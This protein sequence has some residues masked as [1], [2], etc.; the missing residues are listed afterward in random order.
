VWNRSSKCWGP[1]APGP[2]PLSR[3]AGHRGR[4]LAWDVLRGH[5]PRPR[6]TRARV[7]FR[8]GVQGER[9]VYRVNESARGEPEQPDPRALPVHAVRSDP[10][11]PET[12]VRPPNRGSTSLTAW[13]SSTQ[14]RWHVLINMNLSNTR[15]SSVPLRGAD[16]RQR[17]IRAVD[18]RPASGPQP[19]HSR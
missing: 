2:R 9:P 13:L 6:R 17:W 5:V 1:G 11:I 14:N 3:R 10:P 12:T 4:W 8:C 7:G 19:D 15:C 18:L 16:G